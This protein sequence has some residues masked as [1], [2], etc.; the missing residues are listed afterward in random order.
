MLAT[1]FENKLMRFWNHFLISSIWF[2]IKDLKGTQLCY[3]SLAGLVAPEIQIFTPPN[4]L[5]F[6]NGMVSLIDNGLAECDQGFGV[7]V[8]DCS[9]GAFTFQEVGVLK[10]EALG[11]DGFS[12]FEA[13]TS[14]NGV[15]T[16]DSQKLCCYTW[17]APR[18]Y[19]ASNI[20]CIYLCQYYIYAYCLRV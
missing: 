1:R 18:R 13:A 4:A 7:A 12:T 11:A 16:F 9:S 15:S 5:A 20:S 19:A 6:A 10:G 17:D 3:F 2:H 8:S 14:W